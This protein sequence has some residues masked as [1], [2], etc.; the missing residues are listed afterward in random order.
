MKKLALLLL[1]LLSILPIP[2]FSF[3]TTDYARQTG[4]ECK[5]CHVDAIGGGKLTKAGEQFVEEMKLK[6]LYR[7]LKT[8]Q[9]II[10]FIVG[11]VHLLTAI[12][13]FGTILYVHVLLKPAYAAKGLPKGELILGWMSMI[14]MSVTGTLLSIARIPAWDVLFTTRF[15]IL[16]T[17]KVLLFLIMM[18]TAFFVTVFIGPRMKKKMMAMPSGDILKDRQELTLEELHH[19][20]GK[21]GR[22]AYLALKGHIYD[23]TDSRLWKSGSHARKHLAGNDLTDALKIAPHNE[24]KV[25]AMR[26]VGKLSIS[27]A[28]A[29]RPLHERIFYFFA[30][31]N[32]V[33]VFLI[34]FVIALMRWA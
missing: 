32:L 8:P 34:V 2:T 25:L 10:R 11:Y 16:L 33:F 15:G 27:E 20:D 3:A 21:E 9:K 17:I 12:A 23:V 22:P 18:G 6:G 24:E 30:Y 31:M 29:V 14:I 5:V 13:W 28:K 1:L 19:F 4:F 26:H 7:P